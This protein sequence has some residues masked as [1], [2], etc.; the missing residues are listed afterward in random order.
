MRTVGTLLDSL[1]KPFLERDKGGFD[2]ALGS[3]TYEERRAV[4]EWLERFRS[5]LRVNEYEKRGD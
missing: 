5:W 2:A 1:F 4:E 3:M